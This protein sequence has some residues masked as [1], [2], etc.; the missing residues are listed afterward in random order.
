MDSE[1]QPEPM[2]TTPSHQVPP[3]T[4]SS[5]RPF[6]RLDLDDSDTTTSIRKS[7]ELLTLT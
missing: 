2:R 5:G 1:N 3:S 6:T 7:D 4:L